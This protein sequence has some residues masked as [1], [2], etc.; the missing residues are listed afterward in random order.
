M[1]MKLKGLMK[2]KKSIILAS[3]FDAIMETYPK[4]NTGFFQK[5]GDQFSNPVGHTFTQGIEST[6]EAIIEGTDLAD[7]QSFLNDIIKVRAV[8]DFTPAKA[9]DFIFILKKVV[10]E[11]LEQE[12]RQDQIYDEFRKFESQVDDL[13]LLA[14]NIYMGCREQINQLKVDELK[15]MTFTLLKKANLAHDIPMEEF[16]IKDPET[17]I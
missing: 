13:A 6:L 3:W 5:Q 15:R 11:Q 4:D 1:D 10:K 7:G 17:S 8:Q 9:V 12:I 2:E 14:F 16:E